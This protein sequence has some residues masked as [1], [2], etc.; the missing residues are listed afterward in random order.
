MTAANY[1][2]LERANRV[3]SVIGLQFGNLTAVLCLG[4][5]GKRIFWLCEC[6]CGTSVHVE[7]Y[8]LR[9]GHTTSCG[10]RKIG[11]LRRP[12]SHG[13]HCGG[14]HP[15]E[16]TW[17]GLK[18]RCFNVKDRNYQNYGA[19]GITVC[20]RWIHGEDGLSG[21]ECFVIDMGEKPTPE[22]S[23]DRIDNDGN[24]EPNNCRWATKSEQASNRRPWGKRAQLEARP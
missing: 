4:A 9:S 20:G 8:K 2:P 1:R 17:S 11:V 19:R 18:T 21:F 7:S 16:R 23:I 24:Y 6:D 3:K 10:C 12:R 15:M 13:L 5:K 22:H 14:R